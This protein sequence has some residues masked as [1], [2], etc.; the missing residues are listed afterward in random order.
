MNQQTIEDYLKTIYLLAETKKPVSTTRIAKARQVQ[1]ASV[2]QMMKRLDEQGLVQHRKHYGVTLTAEG[3]AIALKI[4]RHHRLLELYL[5]QE[6]GY[7][8]DEVHAEAD[9]LEHVISEKLEERLT[10]V[11]GC[12]KFDPHGDPIPAKDGTVMNLMAEPLSAL[13]QGNRAMVIRISDDTNQELLRYLAEVGLK[14]GARL[15][16][17]STA[18]YDGPLTLEINNQQRIVGHK[19]AGTVYVKRQESRL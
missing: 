4:I 8:W 17:V 9:V 12:P 11:L 10:A 1:P 14:P 18:P 6:L 7:G 19:A 2:T 5:I 15:Q 16:V 13:D 3:E